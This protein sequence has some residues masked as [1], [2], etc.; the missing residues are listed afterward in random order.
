MSKKR[1]DESALTRIKEEITQFVDEQLPK[2]ADA[3]YEADSEN[4]HK[5]KLAV[6]IEWSF[7]PET[8]KEPTF[9]TLRVHAKI[10]TP[11]QSTEA[12]KVLWDNGQM[13]LL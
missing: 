11:K 13:T 9:E 5:G 3:M 1:M 4:A 7:K 2:L 10:T 12:A 6:E 8:G